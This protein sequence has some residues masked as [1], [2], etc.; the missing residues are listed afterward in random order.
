MSTRDEAA[1][2]QH[3]PGAA[4]TAPGAA[5]LVAGVGCSL[6]C[7]A[8][9]L[10]ALVDAALAEAPGTLVALATVDRRASE[11]C[12]VEAL[13]AA[14]HASKRGDLAGACRILEHALDTASVC[15]TERT[16]LLH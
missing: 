5:R 10:L 8:E 4:P 3:A 1:P 11:P 12:M 14:R 13:A 9:E 6:G 15:A 2:A 16:A 7:P